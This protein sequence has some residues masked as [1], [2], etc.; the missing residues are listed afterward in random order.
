MAKLT[1]VF[2][3]ADYKGENKRSTCR[4]CYR[5]RDE[6]YRDLA[7]FLRIAQERN[8]KLTNGWLTVDPKA[9]R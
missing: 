7:E 5:T 6:Q 8:A 1:C 9:A 4:I 3:G 2:C